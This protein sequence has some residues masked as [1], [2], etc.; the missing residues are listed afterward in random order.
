MSKAIRV[1]LVGLGYWG[2]HFLRIVNELPGAELAWCCDVS[3]EALDLPRRRYPGARVT[4]DIT[5]VLD[6]PAVDAVVIATPPTTHAELAVAA[7]QAGKHLLIEKP[8]ATSVVECNQIEAAQG[9]RIVMV[10]HTFVYNTAVVA[11]RDMVV[12]GEL[13]QIHYLSSIRAALGP[14][15]TD[16][17]VLWD[18]GSH[19]ISIFMNILDASPET[20]TAVGQ[21]YLRQ[22]HEDVVYLCLRF[23]NGVL[24]HAHVSW[25]EP[26]KVR[27]MTIVGSSKM[28]VFD[29]VAVDERLKVLDRGASWSAPAESAR[30]QNFGE[31]RAM[32]RTGNI[33]VPHLPNPEPLAQQF[34]EFLSALRGQREPYSGLREGRRVVAVLDAAQRSLKQSGA[35]QRVEDATL[36]TT[37]RLETR[38]AVVAAA[39]ARG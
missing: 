8:L 34:C 12:S 18:L 39:T 36:D 11:L 30:G 23:P 5:Q 13:G 35:P 27:R 38:R 15:R 25:L 16:V 6:D 10:G 21:G 20:V 24:A 7:L 32:L 17:N 29:D 37:M 31:Y 2:P 26:Y 28:A 33:V 14:L 19:D 3:D 1:G 22:G 9:D 4:T